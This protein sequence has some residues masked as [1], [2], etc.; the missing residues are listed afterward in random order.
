MAYPDLRAWIAELERHG[1]LAR[2]RREVDWNLEIGAI[3]RRI[4]ETQG[5]APLFETV[6][7]YPGCRI[8]GA[9]VAMSKKHRYG[10]LAL[11]LGLP[12]DSSFREIF[13]FYLARRKN[14]I[15]PIEVSAGSC[16]ENV[17][18]GADDV[19]LFKLPAP[20]IHDGDGGRYLGTWHVVISRNL[21]GDWTNYGMYRLMIH[22]RR[23][24]GINLGLLQHLYLQYQEYAEQNRPMEFAAAIGV[25]PVTALIGATSVGEG[26]NEA[27][28][29]GGV[30]G[31]PLEVVRCKT[32]DLC[33]PATAEIVIEG[34][35][36]PRER[37]DEGPFGEYVGYRAGG[38]NP[39]PVLKVQAIT[40]RNN[41]ILP[42]CALG[43][44]IDDVH[45]LHSVLEAAEVFE[46]LR[47]SKGFPVECVYPV[48]EAA[49]HLWAVSTDVPDKTY[50]RRLAMALWAM[51]GGRYAD[52]L[53]LV[54]KDV[55]VTDL[56][57][58]LWAMATRA[59]PV[60][61]LWPVEHLYSTLL[62]PWLTPEE[63]KTG[64]GAHVLIDATWPADWPKDWIPEVSSF[65]TMWPEEVQR[66]VLQNWREDGLGNP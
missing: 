19:D 8:L 63:R 58:L 34:T 17:I 50:P 33:V 29:I 18:L 42:M 60:R 21:R 24:L 40:H 61:D 35:I 12:V 7:G 16:Q 37:K 54:N 14:R 23:H 65:K 28:V 59:H 39:R 41:P 36:D 62:V 1:E 64:D 56:R 55:D 38:K 15:A 3:T 5:P 4:C 25:E 13:E 66:K 52:Y 10:R 6:K 57:E 31:E 49:G 26:V 20:Y 47:D 46:E 9:P 22:D 2:V 53:V 11:S 43:T 30:R 51:K 27:E 48:P 45:T 32:V 44:P